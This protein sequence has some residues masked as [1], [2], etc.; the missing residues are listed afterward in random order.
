VR[1]DRV[2]W[3]SGKSRVNSGMEWYYVG[4]YGQL[5]PLTLDQ[6]QE[7]ARDGVIERETYVWRTGLT[8]WQPAH[9]FSE[10][11]SVWVAAPSGP[12]PIPLHG[13]PRPAPN[14]GPPPSP[15]PPAPTGD[16]P[17]APTQA[18]WPQASAPGPMPMSLHHDY[19][20]DAA[21]PSK[22]SRILA[23]VLQLCI[24]GVGRIYLGHIAEGVM[25]FLLAFLCFGLGWIWSIIDGI[26]MLVGSVKY[27]GYGRKLL[28]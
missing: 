22:K 17:S 27:D 9:T 25:Q 2:Q 18:G 6:I 16:A 23:G 8:D 24:P 13:V 10:F 21:V 7:L 4:H 14:P 28:D 19:A 12:P 3:G 5:G 20:M 15:Y 26:M 11:V 1:P